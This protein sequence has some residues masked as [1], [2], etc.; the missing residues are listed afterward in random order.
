MSSRRIVQPRRG[1]LTGRRLRIGLDA[2]RSSCAVDLPAK[3][4][5]DGSKH[6]SADRLDAHRPAAGLSLR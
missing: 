4:W 3:D 1:F 6:L 2:G 5:I